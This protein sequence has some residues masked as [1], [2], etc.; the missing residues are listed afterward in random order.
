MVPIKDFKAC[1]KAIEEGNFKAI[2]LPPFVKKLQ[3]GIEKLGDHLQFAL[4]KYC[5]DSQSEEADEIVIKLSRLCFSKESAS[6]FLNIERFLGSLF[7][8]TNYFLKTV[9]T[10]HILC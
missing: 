5:K 9:S 10:S 6:G 3:D 2:D 1:L 8:I 7:H 4:H